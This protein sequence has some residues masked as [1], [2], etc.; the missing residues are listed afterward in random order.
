[1]RS[2]IDKTIGKFRTDFNAMVKTFNTHDKIIQRYDEVLT[3]KANKH[4]LADVHME[5][6]RKI[7][8]GLNPL[9]GRFC[10]LEE[11]YRKI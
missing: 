1:M 11:K 6:V 8:K 5:L 7:D 4:S 2:S 10:G 3:N 9:D